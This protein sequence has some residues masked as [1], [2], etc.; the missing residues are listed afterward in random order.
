MGQRLTQNPPLPLAQKNLFVLRQ[1]S[2][3]CL[4]VRSSRNPN[5][6]GKHVKKRLFV[7]VGGGTIL[8]SVR[9]SHGHVRTTAMKN[10]EAPAVLL[11]T[12]P[13]ASRVMS[14]SQRSLWSLTACGAIPCVK[15]GRSVRYDLEDLRAYIRQQKRVGGDR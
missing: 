4:G 5:T 14:I 7:P 11:L 1:N 2:A 3:V 9:G 15:I 6:K 12:P 8:T 13:A 10:L